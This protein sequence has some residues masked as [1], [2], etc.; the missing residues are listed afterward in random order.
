ME[1]PQLAPLADKRI[2]AM[3]EAKIGFDLNEEQILT[4]ELSDETLEAAAGAGPECA[5]AFTVTMCTGQA[6]CPF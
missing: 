2:N 3:N 6:D 4:D 1:T 5:R